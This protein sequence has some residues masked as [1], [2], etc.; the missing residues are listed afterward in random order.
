MIFIIEKPGGKPVDGDKLV[1]WTRNLNQNL[2]RYRIDVPG[3]HWVW[4]RG[5]KHSP[6]GHIMKM[7][8]IMKILKIPIFFN[9]GLLKISKGDNRSAYNAEI[10]VFILEIYCRSYNFEI[11][12]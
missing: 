1:M 9:Q 5:A 12:E 8:K 10:E 3:S 2:T 6:P 11:K 7:L 4:E